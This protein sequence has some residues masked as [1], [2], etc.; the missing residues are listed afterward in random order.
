M[1]KDLTHNGQKF[2]LKGLLGSRWECVR[3]VGLEGAIIYS[4]AHVSQD[5]LHTYVCTQLSSLLLLLC[6]S[7]I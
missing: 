2:Y 3:E 6:H 4:I 5:M 7:A 1:K